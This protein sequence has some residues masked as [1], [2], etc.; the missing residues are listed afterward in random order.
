LRA[1]PYPAEAHRAKLAPPSTFAGETGVGQLYA[2]EGYRCGLQS[3]KG[4]GSL[5]ALKSIAVNDIR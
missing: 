3:F 2:K 5:Q 4:L 1:R